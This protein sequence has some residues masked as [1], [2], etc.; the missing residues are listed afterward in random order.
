MAD[1]MFEL[2]QALSNTNRGIR[3]SEGCAGPG[4]SSL[5]HCFFSVSASAASLQH[6]PGAEFGLRPKLDVTEAFVLRRPA[7]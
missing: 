1:S 6:G 4:F 7:R 2:F 5:G 3:L